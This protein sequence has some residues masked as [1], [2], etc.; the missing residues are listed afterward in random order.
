MK[1]PGPGAMVGQV[2]D[3]LFRKPA[4]TR[5]PFVKDKPSYKVRGKIQFIPELC[6]GCKLCEKDCPSDAIHIVKTG[7]KQWSAEFDLGKC[8]YCGQ[9]VD[10]CLKKALK[11][12]D[13]FELASI[14]R[15]TLKV[16][17]SAPK[18]EETKVPETVPPTVKVE[19]QTEK[20]D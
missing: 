9:C 15:G 20:Q 18:K 6:I 12:T 10:S 13:E 4:T 17:F 5:Y 14:V 2:L 1:K 3:S 11:E 16:V 19:G 7:E 8:I